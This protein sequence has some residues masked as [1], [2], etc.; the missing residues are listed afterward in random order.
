MSTTK[1]AV[2][3]WLYNLS[4]ITWQPPCGAVQPKVQGY[5]SGFFHGHHANQLSSLHVR[6]RG[7]PAAPQ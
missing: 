5:L 2:V 4:P 6:H 7:Q 3:L 1:D